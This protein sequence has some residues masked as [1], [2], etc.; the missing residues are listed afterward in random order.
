M[1]Q[2]HITIIVSLDRYGKMIEKMFEETLN[3]NAV[4]NSSKSLKRTLRLL[5][6]GSVSFRFLVKTYYANLKI[7]GS[8]GTLKKLILLKIWW[9][10]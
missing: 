6:K 5:T 9:H 4:F 7:I 8:F 10:I 2:S 1:N 3:V